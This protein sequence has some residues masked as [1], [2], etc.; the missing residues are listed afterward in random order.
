MQLT[1]RGR[2]ARRLRRAGE[3]GLTLV[4]LMV[5]MLMMGVLGAA[6]T[7]TVVFAQHTGA[8]TED[9]LFSINRAHVGVDA[10][11]RALRTAVQP[12]QFDNVCTSC[13]FGSNPGSTALVSASPSSVEFY[14][15][16]NAVPSGPDLV[17]FA[18]Q[19]DPADSRQTDLVETYQLPIVQTSGG[20]TTFSFCTP[21]PGCPVVT[22]TLVRGVDTSIG[23]PLFTYY[24]DTYPAAGSTLSPA[25]TPAALSTTQLNEVDSVD[26][27]LAVQ[28]TAGASTWH[29]APVTIVDHIELP[30]AD[31]A[32]VASPSPTPSS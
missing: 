26:L 17:T 7:T 5:A 11:E 27:E 13:S 32:S 28:S 14:A 8:A 21:G 6:I 30:N 25:G 2:V 18:L 3:T 31:T 15:N 9:R 12:Q 22:R 19:P 20:S 16:L 1:P 10:I 4:E 23:A 24:S 29:V